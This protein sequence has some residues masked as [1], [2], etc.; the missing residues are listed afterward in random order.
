MPS[1]APASAVPSAVLP[2][3][4]HSFVTLVAPATQAGS[5]TSSSSTGILLPGERHTAG[6]M[7]RTSP[8]DVPA[9]S[10]VYMYALF[11]HCP[12]CYQVHSSGLWDP[13][14][15]I[16]AAIDKSKPAEPVTIT[17]EQQ[18]QQQA[19]KG[20]GSKDKPHNSKPVARDSSG[21]GCVTGRRYRL[22]PR[23]T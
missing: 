16:T 9:L 10:V 17:A 6:L 20:T 12:C 8:A 19:P 21:S 5:T 4:H 22:L 13:W 3:L 18:Q 2:P 14:R 1:A 23:W 7:W 11:L 15:E